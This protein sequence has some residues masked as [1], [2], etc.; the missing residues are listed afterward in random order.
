MN[1]YDKKSK[2]LILLV[3][4]VILLFLLLGVTRSKTEELG[5]NSNVVIRMSESS[6]IELGVYFP[7]SDTINGASDFLIRMWHNSEDGLYYLFL[8]AGID[9]KEMYWLL[10][11][12]TNIR[13]EQKKIENFKEKIANRLGL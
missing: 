3:L 6:E 11:P 1:I 5:H 12:E 2:M 9:N 13:I 4:T 10:Q 8:P 7:L